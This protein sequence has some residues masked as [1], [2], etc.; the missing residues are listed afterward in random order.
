MAGLAG[1]LADSVSFQG[2]DGMKYSGT[3]AGLMDLWS[4]HRDSL[5]SVKITVD[6][7]TKDHSIDKND[8]YILVWYKEIDTYKSGKVDSASFAD[9]NQMKKGKIS[10]YSQFRQELKMK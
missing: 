6:A 7:W 9:I 5:S 8:D 2:F 3:K 10:W 4:K 1:T